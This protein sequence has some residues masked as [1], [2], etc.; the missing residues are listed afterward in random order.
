MPVTY[1]AADILKLVEEADKSK[2]PK[3]DGN[4]IKAGDITP[5][6]GKQKDKLIITAGFKIT[7]KKTRLAYTVQSVSFENGDVVMHATSGDGLEIVIPSKEFKQ[8]ERL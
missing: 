2:K 3:K 4:Y 8:Y 1:T 7:H 6:V 5:Y